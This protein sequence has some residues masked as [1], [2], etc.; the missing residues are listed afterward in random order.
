[1]ALPEYIKTY[2]N[3]EFFNNDSTHK[4]KFNHITKARENLSQKYKNN[5]S[6]NNKNKIINSE[7]EIAAYL[8]S[9][10]PAT[11][12][13]CMNIFSQ[14]DFLDCKS[15]LDIGSGPG[16]V[17]FACLELIDS[18]QKI[19]IV[20]RESLFIKK[21]KQIAE[22][23]NNS[24]LKNT[25]IFNKNA[26]DIDDLDN[27]DLVT[28]SYVLNELSSDQQ[29]NLVNKIF[30]KANKYIVLIEPGTPVG[31]K[32]IIAARNELLKLNC[33]IIAPCTH[34]N[35]CPLPADDWCHFKQR[36]E[37]SS[38]QRVLKNAQESYEDE[39]FSYLIVSKNSVYTNLGLKRIIRHP[40]IHK[41]H[42]DFKLCS[43][44]GIEEI[45]ISKKDDNYKASKKKEWGH[46]L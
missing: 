16:T 10:L 21:F 7:N 44:K 37:R 17:V 25:N 8:L 6:N 36:L 11:F 2:L 34:N 43:N 5:Q 45:T 13:V 18:I 19:S 20:E 38:Y 42:I 33:N 4:I 35:K 9:R 27:H 39:K 26:L 3:N 46:L 23:S 31:Y 15:L 30:N 40:Q 32:N 1:M 28:C 22:A 14:D 41:G 29:L 12:S 24:I